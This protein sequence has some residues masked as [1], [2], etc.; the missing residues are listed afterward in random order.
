MG[1]GRRPQF[2]M[3]TLQRELTIRF[4]LTEHRD[5][6]ELLVK[7]VFGSRQQLREAQKEKSA[8]LSVCPDGIIWW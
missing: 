2:T 4:F 1:C 8:Y 3:S 5:W 7:E 6:F